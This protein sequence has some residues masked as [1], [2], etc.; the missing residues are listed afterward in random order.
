MEKKK[1]SAILQA[2]LYLTVFVGFAVSYLFAYPQYDVMIFSRDVGNSIADAVGESL[3]YGNGRFLGNVLGFYFSNHFVESLFFTSLMMTL[4]TAMLNCLFFDGRKSCIFPIAVIIAFPA[5]G[6][7]REVY[8]MLAAFCNYAV[9]LLFVL[10]T[11]IILKQ[12]RLGGSRWL[13]VPLA[14]S[15]FC[16]CLFSENTTVV[17]GCLAFLI[18]V[19]EYIDKKKIMPQSIVNFVFTAAGAM[20]M[21]LIPKLTRTSEKLSDYRSFVT[22]PTALYRN[23][24]SGVRAF[25]LIANQFV[26]VYAV[27]S[28]VM[29]SLLF[30]SRIAKALKLLIAAILVV[31]PI[32]CI[33]PICFASFAYRYSSV[34]IPLEIAYLAAIIIVAIVTKNKNLIWAT[35]MTVVLLGSAVGPILIVNHRGDRTFFTVFAIFLFYAA[36]LAT[37]FGR[38][39]T[40][41]RL[42]KSIRIASPILFAAVCAF[43]FMQSVYNFDGYAFRADKIAQERT[44]SA[45]I[46]VPYLP[47]ERFAA[48]SKWGQIDPFIFG[49]ELK[50][51]FTVV[52]ADEWEYAQEYEKIKS[53]PL[54]DAVRYAA[55]H[56]SFKDPE[57]PEKLYK[58]YSAKNKKSIDISA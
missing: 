30:R 49:D 7:V 9:P 14:L 25:A 13:Y 12:M 56:W 22:E 2:L 34:Y 50:P 42:K 1:S 44:V 53:A 17:I 35:L 32:S 54:K 38:E 15:A 45:E 33:F 46:S 18:L 10:L 40:T 31:F 6:I 58:E 21:Y 28:F 26:L 23:V 20:T 16:S 27:I 19:R 36:Y 39:I 41:V 3:Y 47:R 4:F 55:S 8:F 24:I 5:L 29:L 52:D 51:T 48:E 43:V 11:C 37:L 57:Y